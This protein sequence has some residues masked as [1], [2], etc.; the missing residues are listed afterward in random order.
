LGTVPDTAEN[1]TTVLN[2]LALLNG[3]HLLRVHDVKKAR[4]AIELVGT[5]CNFAAKLE[6]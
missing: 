6:S 1:G 3:A 4:E 2:T 5:F